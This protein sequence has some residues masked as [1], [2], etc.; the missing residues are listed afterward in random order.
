M[1]RIEDEDEDLFCESEGKLNPAREFLLI[2]VK[3]SQHSDWKH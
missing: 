3:N 1:M 2:H